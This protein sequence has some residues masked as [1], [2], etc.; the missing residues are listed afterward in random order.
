[1]PSGVS[2]NLAKLPMETY[3]IANKES[4]YKSKINSDAPIGNERISP[5]IAASTKNG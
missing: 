3:C 2:T 4:K 1:M 5:R